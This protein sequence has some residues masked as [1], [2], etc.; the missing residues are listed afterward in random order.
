MRIDHIIHTCHTHTMETKT[1]LNIELPADLCD[2]IQGIA[3][4]GG[5]SVTQVIRL[6]LMLYKVCH[7]AKKDGQHFGIVNDA[8]KLDRELVG[9]I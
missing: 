4:G 6:A 5:T 9:L 1:R 3:K 2:D 7:Q 8:S